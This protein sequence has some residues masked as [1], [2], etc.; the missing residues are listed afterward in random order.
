MGD[1]HCSFL[2]DTGSIDQISALRTA[3]KRVTI[4]IY[5]EIEKAYN[6]MG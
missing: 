1:E 3:W 5:V 6:R 4:D 2:I